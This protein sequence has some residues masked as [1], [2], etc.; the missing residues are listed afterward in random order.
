MKADINA[1]ETAE[2]GRM[3][4]SIQEGLDRM[5]SVSSYSDI[6]RAVILQQSSLVFFL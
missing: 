3:N 6:R 2:K 5:L 1:Y 4:T